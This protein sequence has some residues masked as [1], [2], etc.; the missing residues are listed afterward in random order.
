MERISRDPTE[1]KKGEKEEIN[2]DCDGDEL[3]RH[4]RVLQHIGERP[5]VELFIHPVHSSDEPN[6]HTVIRLKKKISVK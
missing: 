1:A 5:A 4:G 3:I 2:A 6:Y